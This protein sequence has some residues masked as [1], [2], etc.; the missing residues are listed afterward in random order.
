[1]TPAEKKIYDIQSPQTKRLMDIQAGR[2][3]EDDPKYADDQWF[4]AIPKEAQCVKEDGSVDLNVREVSQ[5]EY[6][7]YQ[8]LRYRRGKAF[9]E[10]RTAYLM[11]AAKEGKIHISLMSQIETNHVMPTEEVKEKAERAYM[12]TLATIKE[13]FKSL[14]ESLFKP[15]YAEIVA[16]GM[17]KVKP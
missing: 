17:R 4:K 5:K 8:A 6:D 13:K 14:M 2:K 12:G 10:A 3:P 11:K 16:E 15:S 7:D 9:E 1:M